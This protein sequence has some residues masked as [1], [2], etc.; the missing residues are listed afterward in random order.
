MAYRVSRPDANLVGAVGTAAAALL[1]V[2]PVAAVLL[3][4]LALR[5]IHARRRARKATSTDAPSYWA[6]GGAL[7]FALSFIVPFGIY[8]VSHWTQHERSAREWTRF[9]SPTDGFTVLFPE[10]PTETTETVQRGTGPVTLRMVVAVAGHGAGYSV[11][12][13]ADPNDASEDPTARLDRLEAELLQRSGGERIARSTV[14][15]GPVVGRELRILT[16]ERFLRLRF[17]AVNR[18]V[19]QLLVIRP[20]EALGDPSDDRFLDSFT[21]PTS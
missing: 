8:G 14:A 2:L 9:T 21:P 13:G 6:G 19:F 16:R 18:R 3:A 15:A 20:R 12:V 4:A 10:A 7:V 17:F 1:V 11:T 5:E